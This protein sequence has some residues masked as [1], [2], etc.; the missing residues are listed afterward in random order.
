MTHDSY[1]NFEKRKPY[2][3]LPDQ[4]QRDVNA[5][6]SNYN[7]AIETSRELL[8]SISNTELIIENALKAYEILPA[9]VLLD[10]HSL[11]FHKNYIKLLPALL[12]VYVGCG[13]QLLGDL[14]EI[15]LIKIHFH[16]GKV[17][18]MELMLRSRRF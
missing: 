13:N 6:F 10:N 4:I 5:F 3:Q 16:S 15:Q 12:R 2:I 8:Y 9:S 1:L 7:T 11:I 17:S 18:F 14:D